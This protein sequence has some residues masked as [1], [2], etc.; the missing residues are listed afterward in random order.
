MTHIRLSRTLDTTISVLFP[1]SLFCPIEGLRAKC[2]AIAGNF[3][4]L[5]RMGDM[6]EVAAA[7]LFLC[8]KDAQFITGKNF[9]PWTLLSR[10]IYSEVDQNEKSFQGIVCTF[11]TVFSFTRCL[12]NAFSELPETFKKNGFKVYH[13]GSKCD[14][15]AKI[16][17]LETLELHFCLG[18]R[19]LCFEVAFLQLD[20][21]F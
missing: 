18:S 15:L 1:K 13:K 5:G 17:H 16:Q 9:S 19:K 6:A 20:I 11:G 3:H 4:M 8:S 12:S 14:F 21:T 2:E 10:F 7:G